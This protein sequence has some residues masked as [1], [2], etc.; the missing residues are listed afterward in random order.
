LVPI[1]D[2]N[3]TPNPL[4]RY[5]PRH[6]GDG[7]P[8]AILI[9]VRRDARGTFQH[10]QAMLAETRDRRVVLLWDR[11]TSERRRPDSS[12]I[13]ERGTGERRAAEAEWVFFDVRRRRDRRERLES[14]PPERRQAERRRRTPGTRRTLGFVLVPQDPPAGNR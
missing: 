8:P 13:V 2:P 14:R 10:L 3:Q 4:R 7:M 9:V 1:W 5:E 6:R 12:V 11:R